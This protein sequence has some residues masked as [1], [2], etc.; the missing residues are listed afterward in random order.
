MAGD[1]VSGQ[2]LFDSSFT[3]G[4]GFIK[5]VSTTSHA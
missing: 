4:V 2:V 5:S 3:R 1:A